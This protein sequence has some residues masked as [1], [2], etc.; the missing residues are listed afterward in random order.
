MKTTAASPSYS[1]LQAQYDALVKKGRIVADGRQQKVLS[2]LE[3]LAVV[4]HEKPKKGLIAKIR[5]RDK[6]ATQGIYIYGDVGRGKSML[7]DLFFDTLPAKKKRRVHFH[8]FMLEVHDRL[9]KRRKQNPKEGDILPR[10][11]EEIAKDVQVLCFDEFQVTDIA[12]AMMLGRFFTALF[13]EGVTVVATSNRPPEDLYKDGLQRERFL[14]F[15]E[16]LKQKLEVVT[17]TGNTD[18]RLKHLKGLSSVY[19]SPLG[20]KA[21]QFIAHTFAELTHHAKPKERVLEVQGR[22]VKVKKS[23]GDVAWFTF[24]E[25]CAKPLGP[26]DFIE[27]AREFSTILLSGIPKLGKEKRNEA[28]RFV[29]LVDALYEHKTKLVATAAVEP[30]DIYKAGDGSFEFARTFSRLMEMQSER[31]LAEKHIG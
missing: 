30:Q 27:I 10:I 2:L 26:A 6:A 31:Y 3:N 8:A 9:D 12:D 23:Y 11:A 1:S 22:S 20:K 13:E 24:E 4:F 5:K 16:L 17:L 15:I 29:T 18:Y 14:P 7:M 25:L 19:H 28:K 21:D